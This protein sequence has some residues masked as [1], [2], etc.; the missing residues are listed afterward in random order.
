M[1]ISISEL[2]LE[3][4]KD[5][6][7]A[8]VPDPRRE[9]DGLMQFVTEE[10]RTFLLTHPEGLVSEEQAKLFRRFVA[11]RGS[12]EPLQYLTGRQD[13]FGLEFEV[14]PDVLIPRPETELLVEAALKLTDSSK[15]APYICDVGTGSGCIAIALLHKLSH[16]S[17]LGLDISEP[18]IR[19]ARRNAMRHS[20]T[21]RIE[22]IVSDCF[23]ALEPRPVVF[24]LIVSNPPY[25][26]SNAWEGLQR[27]VRQHEPRTALVSGSDGLSMIRRLLSESP[28]FLQPGGHLLFEIGFDQGATVERLIDRSHWKLLGIE[29]DLQ[30][31]PRIVVLERAAAH[32][33]K[34]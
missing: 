19:V 32:K 25:V 31:I 15:G 16:A 5:L 11:R 20:V 23:S 33:D 27:E 30:G 21:E 34:H 13:F 3:A 29:D 6:Q 7:L 17:A 2:I 9:A 22:F 28:A 12:G 10:E 8:G 24:D 18:A 1:S 14:T 26:A 4:T